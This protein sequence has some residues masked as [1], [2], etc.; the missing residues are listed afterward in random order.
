[1]RRLPLKEVLNVT[2]YRSA[3]ESAR[4][5]GL[6]FINSA[7]AAA[8]A[9]GMPLDWLLAII[10]WETGNF[11]ATGPPWNSRNE[12]DNGGGIIGFTGADGSAWEQMT[13]AQQLDLVV[14]Y[15][16]KWK[17]EYDISA[18]R[19][20]IEAYWIVTGPWGLLMNP[21]ADVG[22]GRKRQSIVDIMKGVFRAG[23]LSWVDPN[24]GVEGQWNVRIGN[25]METFGTP[26]RQNLLVADRLLPSEKWPI[27]TV[28][29]VI[30]FTA[31]AEFVG[32]SAHRA[33]SGVSKF[34]CRLPTIQLGKE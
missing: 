26:R 29:T 23:G 34:R 6:E 4:G 19:S 1:M 30:G 5:Y 7:T 32:A 22:G 8:G 9:I 28:S 31:M 3:A 11:K 13:P 20:P 21:E 33:T 18:F 10:S 14:R 17:A 24:V 15:F 2:D 16:V 12:K 25:W 27:P